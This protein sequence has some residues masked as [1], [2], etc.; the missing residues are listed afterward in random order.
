MYVFV[1]VVNRDIFPPKSFK[2]EGEARDALFVACLDFMGID[3]AEF[4]DTYAID[5]YDILAGESDGYEGENFGIG[6]NHA[7]C[8]RGNDAWDAKVFKVGV[9]KTREKV[10]TAEA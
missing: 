10:I 6:T 1:E 9:E 3:V 8:N 4:A 7:W 2:T 5:P